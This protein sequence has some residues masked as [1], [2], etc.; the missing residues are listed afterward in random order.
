MIR[1]LTIL[2]AAVALALSAQPA[3]AG[4][5]QTKY[6][7]KSSPILMTQSLKGNHFNEVLLD[8]Q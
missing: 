4:V 7:D 3:T 2:G 6:L 8:V 1:V 5:A